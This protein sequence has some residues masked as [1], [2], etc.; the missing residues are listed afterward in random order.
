LQLFIG[1]I[2]SFSLIA[3]SS[4]IGLIAGMLNDLDYRDP[5]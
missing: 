3:C 5:S 2:K 1:E 4:V